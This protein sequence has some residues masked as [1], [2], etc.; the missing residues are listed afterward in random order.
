MGLFQHWAPTRY[1]EAVLYI[2]ITPNRMQEV[3][4]EWRTHA[5]TSSA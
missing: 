5:S 1:A 4:E 2:T 3:C